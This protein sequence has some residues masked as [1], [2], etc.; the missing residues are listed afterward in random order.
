MSESVKEPPAVFR[1]NPGEPDAERREQAAGVYVRHFYERMPWADAYFQVFPNL[2]VKRHSAE[3]MA[4]RLVAWLRNTY[5][6]DIANQ[7][8]AHGLGTDDMLEKLRR[9][10]EAKTLVKVGSEKENVYDDEGRVV[11]VIENIKFREMIDARALGDAIGKQMAMH[12]HG[13]GASRKPLSDE[14]KTI[15]GERRLLE[16]PEDIPTTMEEAIERGEPITLI[17][18]P[19]DMTPEEWAREWEAY[20]KEREEEERERGPL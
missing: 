8:E 13:A 19:D 14:R 7:M 15:E 2:D 11:K 6:L 3:T 10:G 4:C 20:Q 16:Q 12:G 9:L 1:L 5:P 17:E 18:H